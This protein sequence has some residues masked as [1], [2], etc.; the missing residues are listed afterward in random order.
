MLSRRALSTRRGFTIRQNKH[1]RWALDEGQIFQ[2]HLGGSL[3]PKVIWW[4]AMDVPRMELQFLQV[5]EE[6]TIVSL[7]CEDLAQNDDIAAVIR[8]VGPTIVSTALLDGPQ[9]T[10]RWAARYASVLAD[11]PGS[12]VLTLTSFAWRS[13][14]QPHT[15]D[16]SPVI[17]LM[18]DADHGAREI[19]LKPGSHGVLLILS[20]DR[21][22]RRSADGRRPVTTGTHYSAVA[23]HQVRASGAGTGASPPRPT[24]G[25]QLLHA[26]EITILT[27]WAEG[28]AEALAHAP[29]RTQELLADA[30]ERA[31][32][33]TAF[34]LAEPT[35]ALAGAVASIGRALAAVTPADGVPSFDAMLVLGSREPARRAA[36]GTTDSSGAALGARAA[37][38]PSGHRRC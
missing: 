38:H 29:G 36:T 24:P 10:S 18:K 7:V 28:V 16:P 13:A 31:P 5:G 37:S 32:W 14:S 6:V 2:Y 27:G 15:H 23:V 20:G 21:A 4:E 34:G 26:E 1:H 30:G 12:A 9:L 8:A 3:H 25:D 33:R 11:D 19:A 22:T 35:P 17:A